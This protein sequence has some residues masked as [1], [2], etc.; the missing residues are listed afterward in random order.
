MP[1]KLLNLIGT[2]VLMFGVSHVAHAHT[3]AGY[4]ACSPDTNDSGLYIFLQNSVFTFMVNTSD[5][6]SFICGGSA[7]SHSTSVSG[8]LV[9]ITFKNV[10]G[11]TGTI[12]LDK[13]LLQIQPPPDLTVFPDTAQVDVQVASEDQSQPL[14]KFV[15]KALDC[16][17][18]LL[19]ETS[20]SHASA[21]LN[22]F[23]FGNN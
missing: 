12:N 21:E 22:K 17:F 2:L 19:S 8:S 13:I 14:S 16:R 5:G 6:R 1:S 18:G 7:C 3:N 20:P 11:Q 10:A 9:S 23:I 4:I 15:A